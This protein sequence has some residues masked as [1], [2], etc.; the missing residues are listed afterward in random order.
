LYCIIFLL[1]CAQY[2]ILETVILT[3]VYSIVL[4]SF[5]LFV[6]YVFILTSFMS[7]CCMT[8]FMDLRN[9]MCVCMYMEREKKY[10]QGFGG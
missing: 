3:F 2:L 4:C 6:C 8:E 1:Y 7:D 9:Y 10:V 5:V